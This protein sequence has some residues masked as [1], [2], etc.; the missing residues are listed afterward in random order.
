[1]AWKLNA[2]VL[3]AVVLSSKAA[4]V[5]RHNAT[6][7]AGSVSHIFSF[8]APHPSNPML[9]TKSGGC[10]N[11]YRVVAWRDDLFVDNEDIVPTLLSVALTK[12][13]HPDLQTLNVE[14]EGS[15]VLSKWSCGAN[16]YRFTNPDVGLHDKGGYME[17]VARLDSSYWRLQEASAVGLANSYENNLNTVRSTAQAQGWNLV[18]TSTSGEDVSHLFQDPSSLRC[19][20]SFE[21][22]DSF[23]DFVA[24]AEI[25]RVRFCDLPQ[26]IHTGFRK[27]L[28]RMVEA[29]SWQN[30][31][32]SK[33]GSCSSVDAT[34]HSLGGA[35][36]TL[37]TACVS[38]QNGS[39]EYNK[40]SWT[41]GRA[42]RLS[43]V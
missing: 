3:S 33:L 29:S 10:F 30:N 42:K 26:W 16:P 18:G 39:D 25:L 15:P 6:R 21:G 38:Y 19:I 2:V 13:D 40:M 37:F 4:R 1:M 17:M 22:S 7:G 5:A 23:N 32:R 34:G 43:S 41:V 9:T 24:D 28:M 11:G 27:E 14:K 31:V 20:I 35:T 36:A 8:G 12:Y